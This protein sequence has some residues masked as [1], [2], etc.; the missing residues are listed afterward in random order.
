MPITID[1]RTG[2]DF[3]YNRT[4]DPDQVD[5]LW[6]SHPKERDRMLDLLKKRLAAESCPPEQLERL[7]LV[8]SAV[9]AE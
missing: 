6:H 9:A 5:N 1:P 8:P 2:E 7:G 4:A 3:L